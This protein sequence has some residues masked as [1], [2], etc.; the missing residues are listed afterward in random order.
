MRWIVLGVVMVACSGE[1]EEEPDFTPALEFLSP[2]DGDTVDA[3]DVQVSIIVT[4][5]ELSPPE[6]TA[7]VT[8]L[9]LP[10]LLLEPSALAHNEHGTPKGY[11]EL[12]LDGTAVGQMDGTQ[13][14]VPGVTAGAHELV[15]ELVY[16]DGDPLE[17]P[18][19]VTIGFTAE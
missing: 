19:V 8:P 4:D 12:T 17:E 9:P 15:G 13:L 11:V 14:T 7:S 16:A 3:G 6:S 10:L 2:A 5:F 18:V 1:K